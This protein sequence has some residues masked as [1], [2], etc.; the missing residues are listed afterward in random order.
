MFQ[1][2]HS[3]FL[4]H[5]TPSP[6]HPIPAPPLFAPPRPT[7]AHYFLPSTESSPAAATPCQTYTSTILLEYNISYW[8]TYMKD[9]NRVAN[10]FFYFV[11]KKNPQLDRWT[12]FVK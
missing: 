8:N 10:G 6:F 4:P 11:V 3:L 1:M 7:P 2:F 12:P 9:I 5:P